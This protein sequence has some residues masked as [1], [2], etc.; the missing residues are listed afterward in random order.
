MKIHYRIDGG[1]T[2]EGNIAGVNVLERLKQT[3]LYNRIYEVCQMLFELG[4]V[5]EKNAK[6]A[7]QLALQRD[8][9]WHWEYKDTTKFCLFWKGRL[10]LHFEQSNRFALSVMDPKA[11]TCYYVSLKAVENLEWLED[12]VAKPFNNLIIAKDNAAE[13]SKRKT[14]DLDDYLYGLSQVL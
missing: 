6:I 8:G 2:Y 3:P 10:W 12:V 9:Y 5:K 1:T 4:A 7:K 13:E 11:L 14:Q